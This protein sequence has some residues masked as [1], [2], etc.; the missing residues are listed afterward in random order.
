MNGMETRT[1]AMIRLH[2]AYRDHH[3]PLK[4]CR[5]AFH[6]DLNGKARKPTSGQR[7]L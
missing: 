7:L 1:H 6:E 2:L 5:R 4:P 3:P